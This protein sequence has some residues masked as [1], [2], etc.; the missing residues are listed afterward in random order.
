MHPLVIPQEMVYV[1]ECLVS[2][3]ISGT[4]GRNA[5]WVEHREYAVSEGS[6][7]RQQELD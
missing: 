6:G 3:Q 2:K 4:F 1:S 7:D 5:A